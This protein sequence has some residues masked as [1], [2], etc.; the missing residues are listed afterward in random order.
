MRD[1]VI[2]KKLS[3]SHEFSSIIRVKVA[4]GKIEVFFNKGFEP[5]EDIS[6]LGFLFERI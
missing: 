6:H 3:K 5:G 2:S 1:A 4:Y